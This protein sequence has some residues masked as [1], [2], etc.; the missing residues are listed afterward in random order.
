MYNRL[1]TP[2]KL[3]EDLIVDGVNRGRI[4][5]LKPESTYTAVDETGTE[6]TFQNGNYTWEA[7]QFG[8]ADID[9][10]HEILK[11]KFAKYLLGRKVSHGLS[12][13]YVSEMSISDINPSEV[14]YVVAFEN[15]S[16]R[17]S[18]GQIVNYVETSIFMELGM[19]IESN[20]NHLG[21]II[22]M[23]NNEF[24]VE[25]RDGNE[26][27]IQRHQ[28]IPLYTVT[29]PSNID[30]TST[31]LKP[32]LLRYKVRKMF[33]QAF[34]DGEV[35]EMN[36]IN[37]IVNYNVYYPASYVAGVLIPEDKEDLSLGQIVRH[38]VCAD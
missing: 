30:E 8:N 21:R 24:T 31:M 38:L 26:Y 9:D 1:W 20:G 35:T 19:Y 37:G 28:E 7:P 14:S 6:R 2:N 4:T 12:E 23:T 13:G 17:F 33:D 3:G 15:F 36:I 29:V 32:C 22:G 27:Q 11:V 18:L 10:N 25:D 5:T 34:F 16:Q